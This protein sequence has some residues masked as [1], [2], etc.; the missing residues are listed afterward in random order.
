M[1]MSTR[2]KLFVV[3]VDVNCVTTGV[4][5][6]LYHLLAKP[7]ANAKTGSFVGPELSHL[8]QTMCDSVRGK[9]MDKLTSSKL[10][11]AIAKWVAT[12]SG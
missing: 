12:A 1:G 11:T 4:H 6:V 2:P 3:T 7:T 9:P 5:L 8:Q 10:S